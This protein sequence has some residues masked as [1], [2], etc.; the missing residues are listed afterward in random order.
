MC[1]VSIIIMLKSIIFARSAS[2][3]TMP[4]HEY[5][6]KIEQLFGKV[7]ADRDVCHIIARANGGADHPDNYDF[8]RG[9]TWNRMT[10]HRFDDVNC[11]LA[12]KEA[13]KKAVDISRTLC[14]YAGPGADALYESGERAMKYVIKSLST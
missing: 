8:V 13:C 10:G 1:V 11:F 6:K 14:D 9:R 7:D 5:R 4:R 3:R 2:V 12:G